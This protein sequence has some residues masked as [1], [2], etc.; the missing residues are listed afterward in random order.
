[1]VLCLTQL[2]DSWVCRI[3]RGGGGGDSI[4]LDKNVVTA[5]A[6]RR[7]QG[8]LFDQHPPST[9]PLRPLPP[10]HP[11]NRPPT[12]ARFRIISCRR[13]FASI[14]HHINR[15]CG[16]VY[17]PPPAS[18]TKWEWWE[19]LVPSLFFPFP[20]DKLHTSTVSQLTTTTESTE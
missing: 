5:I 14:Y 13:T 6:A 7:Q 20:L 16:G 15:S 8:P 2:P 19:S 3:G 1:M 12:E 9:S 4:R 18:L 11:L 10:T 17:I